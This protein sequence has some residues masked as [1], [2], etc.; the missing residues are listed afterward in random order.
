MITLDQWVEELREDEIRARR[1]GYFEDADRIRR[2]ADITEVSDELAQ[3]CEYFDR[4]V[5]RPVEGHLDGGMAFVHLSNGHSLALTPD[6]AALVTSALLHWLS[7]C[8]PDLYY[9]LLAQNLGAIALRVSP[10]DE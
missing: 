1:R 7:S 10:V 2:L 5:C 8:A 6:R 9:G 3:P 4:G